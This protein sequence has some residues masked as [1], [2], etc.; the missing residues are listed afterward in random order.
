MKIIYLIRRINSV[1]LFLIVCALSFYAGNALGLKYSVKKSIS[2]QTGEPKAV[3]TV[4]EKM[5]PQPKF[6]KSE[7]PEKI[8]RKMM[9]VT[10]SENSHV[11]FDDLAYLT[12]SYIGYDGKTHT[13]NMVVDKELAD[14]VISIFRQL[15]EIEFP[16]EKMRLPYE[17]D[18]VDEMSMRDN[19]TSAF[20]DRPIEGSGGLSFHQLGRAIDINP[21]VNPYVRHSDG[22]VLPT[23]ASKYINRQLDEKGMITEDSQCVEIFKKHGWEWGGDWKSLKDYQHFEK[24]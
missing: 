1:I 13:G 22:V 18:G 8:R 14:E 4:A 7:I 23:T 3:Y 5:M 12:L 16:I 17:Y 24:E 21:L 11:T 19:N 15:Y 6:S 9:N 2:E 20:N 10:I